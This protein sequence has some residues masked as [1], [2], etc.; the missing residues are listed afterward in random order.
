MYLGRPK[1]IVKKKMLWCL[2]IGLLLANSQKMWHIFGQN[3]LTNKRVSSKITRKHGFTLFSGVL[4]ALT[5]SQ[6]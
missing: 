6:L 2:C 1:Y 4:F 5:A 3:L